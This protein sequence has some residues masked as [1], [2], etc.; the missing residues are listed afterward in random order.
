MLA[1]QG[2]KSD[3]SAESIDQ[4]FLSLLK[5]V[6]KYFEEQEFDFLFEWLNEL[7]KKEGELKRKQ[8]DDFRIY[9][10]DSINLLICKVSMFHARIMEMLVN[11]IDDAYHDYRYIGETS[12]LF[13]SKIKAS[14][15]SMANTFINHLTENRD[16]NA[17]VIDQYIEIISQAL[18]IFNN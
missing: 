8:Q 2:T 13:S 12:P 11:A 1:L 15:L 16:I 10:K 3:I 5:T 14:T 17:H 4:Q 18:Q 7:I 9:K 6:E